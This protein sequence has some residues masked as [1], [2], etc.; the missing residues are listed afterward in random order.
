MDNILC[1]SICHFIIMVWI[2]L[3]IESIKKQSEMSDFE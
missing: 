2:H 1:H 3:E